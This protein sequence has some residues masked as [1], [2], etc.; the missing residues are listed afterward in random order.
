MRKVTILGAGL[1]GSILGILLQKKGFQVTIF[2]RRS[3][4]R[5]DIAGGGRSI[6]LALSERG[7][8]ALEYAQLRSEIAAIAMPMKGRY[9]HQEDGSTDFQAYGKN[10]EAINSVSRSELNKKLMDKAESVGV[11]IHFNHR[12]RNVD[13]AKNIIYLT[14]ESGQEKSILCD[15]LFGADGA[16]S[17]LRNAYVHLDRSNYEQSYLKH[18]YIELSIL[19]GSDDQKWLI[20][21][22]GLHI[23]PRHNFMMIALPNTDGSFTCTL[24]FPFEGKLSFESIKEPEEGIAF[25]KEQFP[26]AYPIMPTLL[27]D[28]KNNQVS[29][30][31]TTKIYPWKYKDQSCLI[32]DAAHAVV[33]F[34]GQGMNAGFEDCSI[35]YELIG[36][37]G[38]NWQAIFS[39]YEN[40]RKPNG[41][42]VAD[43]SLLN[44]IEMR[45]KV[46]DPVFLERKKIEKELG[47]RFPNQ[48]NS[49]YEMVSFS[50]IPYEK[51]LKCIKAQD[52][53][54]ES[55]QK[56]GGFFEKL[57]NS[58]YG[59]QLEEKVKQYAESLSS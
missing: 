34:Y 15:L 16:F 49:V 27:E 58:D 46:A 29:S 19:P 40:L 1:V 10:G 17:T 48:F 18:G 47:R 35:L 39:E 42:A 56:E 41:D 12:C 55:I 26:D 13:V 20:Q 52:K 43:L 4:M 5:K 36:K 14:D 25:M 21:N 9:L 37:H 44:F 59:L 8:K 33:P 30:L 31:V 23:W 53:L 22:D 24:F 57:D 2:E 50:H 54:L 11:T 32:G 38:D 7:W 3:D 6:N 51:A 45:D 28:F